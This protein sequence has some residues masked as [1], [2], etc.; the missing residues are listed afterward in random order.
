MARHA[1]LRKAGW[2]REH[3]F[4]IG[5]EYGVEPVW[6]VLVTH[7]RAGQSVAPVALGDS[8][9]LLEGAPLAAGRLP[10]GVAAALITVTVDATTD[11][12]RA[13]VRSATRVRRRA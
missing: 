4:S 8:E 2:G 6:P 1:A 7:T 5:S 12:L 3:H 11:P 10:H 9:P 13:A